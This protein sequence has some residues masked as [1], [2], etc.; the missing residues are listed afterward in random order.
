MIEMII[1]GIFMIISFF[2]GFV[3]GNKKVNKEKIEIP[4][5]N[6]IK[7]IK[8]KKEIKTEKEKYQKDQEITEIN[9]ANIDTY[10]GTGI[11]QRDFP[12]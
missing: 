10:D 9:L 3:L 6:P 1:L 8:E 4:D 7:K 2:L 11:G 12:R 5:I